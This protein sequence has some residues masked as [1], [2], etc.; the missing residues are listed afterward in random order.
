[1][2]N[3]LSGVYNGLNWLSEAYPEYYEYLKA[4]AKEQ[5]IKK[6]IAGQKIRILK[7]GQ[8]YWVLRLSL[9]LRLS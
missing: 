6:L 7:H 3:M 8:R 9:E 1:M 4:E 2:Y 5:I